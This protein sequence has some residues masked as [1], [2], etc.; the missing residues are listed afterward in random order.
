MEVTK[1]KFMKFLKMYKNQII[2]ITNLDFDEIKQIGILDKNGFHSSSL[3]KI[4]F[5]YNKINGSVTHRLYQF[6]G[7]LYAIQKVRHDFSY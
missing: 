7:R 4:C 3:V 5:V 2:D 1:T 6:E